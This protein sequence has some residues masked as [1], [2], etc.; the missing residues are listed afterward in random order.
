MGSALV[1]GCASPM[2]ITFAPRSAAKFTPA[3]MS[4][5]VG[6]FTSTSRNWHSGQAAEI[7]SS[8]AE[9]CSAQLVFAAGAVPDPGA[10]SA[11]DSEI[12]VRHC[13]ADCDRVCA[14]AGRPNWVR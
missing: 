10:I 14:Q 8:C 4:E 1:S 6:E 11:P 13:G 12:S 2:V 3:P 5:M 9:V 7:A